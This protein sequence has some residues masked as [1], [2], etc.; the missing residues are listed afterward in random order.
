M[1]AIK[2]IV[3]GGNKMGRKLGFPTAN[4]L[5][6]NSLEIQNGVYAA[7]VTLEEVSHP[8]MAYLGVKPSIGSGGQRVLEAHIFDFEGQLYDRTITIELGRFI[9]PERRF[10]SLDELRK[11]LQTD[12]Q[13]ILTQHFPTE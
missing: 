4:I 10:E 6:D 11:Q 3:T 1:I 5:V 2:G 12:K 9:R 8:A 7:R 13:C